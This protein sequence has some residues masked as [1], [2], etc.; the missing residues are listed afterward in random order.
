MKEADLK[1]EGLYYRINNFELNRP[2]LVFIHGLSGSSS[3]WIPY[4]KI[5][6][7]R[8]NVLTFD[9]RGHGKSRK[10]PNY[11]DYEIK[12]FAEDLQDLLLYLNISKFILISHSFGTLIALEYIK[13]HRKNVLAT[14]FLSPVFDLEKSFLSKISRPILGLS[15]I[16][17]IFPF[18]P[19]TG[20][21]LN[22]TKF[23]NS[24]DWD[25]KRCY[26]DVQ[27]TTLRIY[28]QCLRQALRR[29]QEHFLEK[30]NV[31][32]LIVHGIKDTMSKVETSI[33]VSKKIKNLELVLIPNADHMVVLNNV[34]EIS[35][36]IE[37]FIEKNGE[38]LLY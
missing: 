37:S 11:S 33:A 36:V 15:K 18:N 34:R 26:A 24:T 7:N 38:N 9:I 30:I 10:F 35:E 29:K 25:I 20:Y 1:K 8:Y 19:K 3:A 5:F 27:N 14:V 4:E 23:P 13:L 2:T 22:Y 12:H 28:F 6:E 17:S 31:P 21:H 32:T 16:F